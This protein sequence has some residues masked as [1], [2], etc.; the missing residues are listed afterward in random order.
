M[1]LNRRSAHFDADL[2]FMDEPLVVTL[3]A[4]KTRVVAVAIPN[5]D[6]SKSMFLAVTALAKDWERYLNGTVD[7]RYLFTVPPVRRLFY[8]DILTMQDGKVMM[9][10]LTEEPDE[11]EL[12]SPRFFSSNHTEPYDFYDVRA[13]DTQTLLIDGEWELTDFGKFQQKFSDIYTFIISEKNWKDTN[14]PITSRRRIQEAFLNRPFQGGFSY[15]HLFS[16]L[17]S[18]IP[19]SDQLNLDKI[20]YA[21]PGHVDIFGKDD[22]FVDLRDIIINFYNNRNSIA[23][24]YNEFYRYLSENRYLKMSGDEYGT[25]NPTEEFVNKKAGDLAKMMLAPNYATVKRLTKNNAL[26][27]AKIVMAFY[28]R[29][30]EASLYFSQGRVAYDEE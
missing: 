12:P 8:F 9:T 3:L 19:R 26:V 1:S 21:S 15:V 25:E 30:S 27:S 4:S 10:P 14:L 11:E 18:N 17:S 7:L 5:E 13:T 6:E 20:Q 2:V 29:L 23:S 28:R 24:A 22:V 16:D